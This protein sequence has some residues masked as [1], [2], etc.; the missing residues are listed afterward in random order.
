MDE[1]KIGKIAEALIA[2]R[3]ANTREKSNLVAKIRRALKESKIGY[4]TKFNTFDNE[5]LQKQVDSKIEYIRQNPKTKEM[6]T[7]TKVES[8]NIIEDLDEYDLD[9]DFDDLDKSVD[10]YADDVQAGLKLVGGTKE[11]SSSSL[12]SGSDSSPYMSSDVTTNTY[13]PD[14]RDTERDSN[15]IY[16]KVKDLARDVVKKYIPQLKDQPFLDFIKSNQR[17]EIELKDDNRVIQVPTMD[18]LEEAN[19]NDDLAMA[20]SVG[21]PKSVFDD[22]PTNKMV[23]IFEEISG[24]SP[25]AITKDLMGK[26]QTPGLTLGEQKTY[27][28]GDRESK[29]S[30]LS[31]T[32]GSIH[33]NLDLIFQNGNPGIME[34]SNAI[35]QIT[36]YM[37]QGGSS[38]GLSKTMLSFAKTMGLDLN[39]EEEEDKKDDTDMSEDQ[40][41]MTEMENINPTLG[42]SSPPPPAAGIQTSTAS[43]STASG[44]TQPTSQPDSKRP[45]IKQ[46]SS[47][48]RFPRPNE[49]KT[50][51]KMM[52][53]SV[54]GYMDDINIFG[55]VPNEI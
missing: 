52:Q 26:F 30:G 16:S 7:Q 13:N 5:D 27:S 46:K 8:K 24:F 38:T 4:D 31:S 17:D 11:K 12:A 29:Y 45:S 33:E 54:N 18:E 49:R 9:K 47:Y 42:S 36:E 37:R 15:L 1:K 6:G 22:I 34:T 43:T 23:K 39:F 35:N 3:T 32:V 2:I 53:N 40:K 51:I 48:A 50:A 28:E 44:A 10:D 14:I 19:S 21:I 20:E 25:N 55:N 41:I